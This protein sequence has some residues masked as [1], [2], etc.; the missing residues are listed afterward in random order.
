[1]SDADV[2]EVARQPYARESWV[3]HPVRVGQQLAR[4]ELS[5]PLSALLRDYYL[6]SSRGNRDN[7]KTR[8]ISAG[9]RGAGR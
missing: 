1:M 5:A 2:L 7:D 6:G 9:Y 3:H 4:I 8:Y